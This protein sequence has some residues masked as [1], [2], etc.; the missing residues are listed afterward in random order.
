MAARLRGRVV[1]TELLGSELLA[2]VEIE[3][4]P[5]LTEEVREVLA[6]VDRARVANVEAEARAQ[7]A[8]F[9]GRF[10]PA[11]RV[12]AGDDIEVAVDLRRLHFFDLDTENAVEADA[13][14]VAT[15][16]DAEAA[17]L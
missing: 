16:A 2:H 6:D 14:A 12:R 17:T 1:A 11:S 8:V 10:D 5:V 15:A 9:I 3:A 7:R 4:K 13:E